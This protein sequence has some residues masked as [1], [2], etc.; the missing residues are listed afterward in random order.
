MLE[1]LVLATFVFF[2]AVSNAAD[3]P[4]LDFINDAMGCLPQKGHMEF[5]QVGFAPYTSQPCV[6]KISN[7]SPTDMFVINVELLNQPPIRQ[8]D[9][10]EAPFH[11]LVKEQENCRIYK[12]SLPAGESTHVSYRFFYVRVILKGSLIQHALQEDVS[13]NES[14]RMGDSHWKEPCVNITITNVGDSVYEAYV[15]ELI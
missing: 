2:H 8:K 12:L 15:C 4:G 10:L 13:W 6:H 7:L 1:S 14:L 3:T 9:A 11:S 5:G